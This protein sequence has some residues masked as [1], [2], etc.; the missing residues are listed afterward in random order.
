VQDFAEQFNALLCHVR[1]LDNLQ[2]VELFVGGL[3]DH[4]RVDVAMRAPQDLPTAMYLARANAI[5]A[6]VPRLGRHARY[7]GHSSRSPDFQ[8]AALDSWGLPSRRRPAPSD[9]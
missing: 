3:P 4:I 9:A 5:L 7:S 2:K 6:I 1:N 8:Q